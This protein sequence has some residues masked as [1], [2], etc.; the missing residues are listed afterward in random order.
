MRQLK[1]DDQIVIGAENF[2][3]SLPAFA[4]HPLQRASRV[5]VDEQLPG[6]GPPFLDDGSGFAPNEF[7]P[8]RA[9]TAVAAK[10]EF[11]GFAFQGAITTFHRLD[12]KRV[13]SA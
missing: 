2:A 8:T 10:R 7:R 6:V 3:V 4:Q 1:A 13:A 9:E 11:I 5:V 12:A